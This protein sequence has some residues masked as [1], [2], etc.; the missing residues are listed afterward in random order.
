MAIQWMLRSWDELSKEEL[1]EIIALRLRVFVVEQNCPYQ[2]VDGKDR[3]SWHLFALNEQGECMT[4]LRILAP[5]VSYN[6]WSIGRVATD[7]RVRGTGLGKELMQRAMAWLKS[8]QG[9]PSVR[10]SAQSYLLRFYESFGFF[11]TGNSYLEDGI[12]HDEMRY[13]PTS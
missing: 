9:H 13:D 3:K 10:I 5:G 12:P 11:A 4:Y 1:Y 6:E 8:Q 7:A 2:D